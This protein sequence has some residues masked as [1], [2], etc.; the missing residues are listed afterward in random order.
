MKNKVILLVFFWLLMINIFALISLNRFNLKGDDAYKW[1]PV[2]KYDQNQGWNIVD[3]HSRWD[4]NWYLDVVRNGYV[5]RENDTLSNIVFFP[6]YPSLIKILS[7]L[8][9]LN[10]VFSGW[11]ISSFFL[12][13][14]AFYLFKIT[15][16]FHSEADPLLA[17]FLLLIFPTSFFLNSVYTESLFLFLSVASFY[18]AAKGKYGISGIF[19]FFAALTR[20]TGILLFVPLL[21]QLCLK[22]GFNKNTL[23]KIFPF[24]LVPLGT[25]SFLLFHWLRFGN[26]FLFFKIE[27]AWGRSF[28]LNVDNFLF[29]SRAAI[30]NFYLDVFYLIFSI[31]I[32]FLL[33]RKKL[34]PYAIYMA[35]TVLVAIGT[36]TLMSIGRYI[37][38][39]FPIFIIGASLKNEI[40]RYAWIMVSIMLMALN[41]I[42]FVNWYWAG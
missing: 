26:F 30:S 21:V 14:G 9:R 27:S 13:L 33:I 28:N 5:L 22:E 10:I 8:L 29:F 15:K 38:V 18:Y 32:I 19:G 3:L 37:L 20:I 7:Y 23:K 16:E 42:L 36:G 31:L 2:D 25:F 4:S 12:F 34:F 35:S 1:I 24:W 6:L 39:L 40:V 41:T 11:M 17:V